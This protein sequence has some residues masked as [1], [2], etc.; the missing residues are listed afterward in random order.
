MATAL[1]KPENAEVSKTH[2]DNELRIWTSTHDSGNDKERSTDSED[3]TL[4]ML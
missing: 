3:G 2:A 1:C 4:R